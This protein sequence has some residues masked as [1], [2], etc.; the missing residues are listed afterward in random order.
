[1]RTRYDPNLMED[2]AIAAI[3]NVPLNVS[4]IGALWNTYMQYSLFVCVLKHF[5]KTTEDF[6]IRPLVEDALQICRLR[7]NQAGDILRR[8]GLPIPQGFKDN[9]V[10]LKAPKLFSDPY[11]LYYIINSNKI[12]LVVNGLSFVTSGRADVRDFYDHCINS[13]IH[14]YNN[15]VNLLLSKGLYIR[16]PIVT[17]SKEV[18]YVNRPDFLSGFLEKKRSLLAQE[19]SN[20]FYG[21]STNNIG[22]RLLMGF[23]QTTASGPG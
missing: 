6:E 13:S 20:L 10:D 2:R 8:E 3:D 16:P 14:L 7:V 21:I 18:D 17:V 11:Y 9:D 1:M 4:E 12:A 23:E 15:T 19:V 5:Q 22:K